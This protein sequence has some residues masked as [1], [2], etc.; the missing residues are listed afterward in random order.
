MMIKLYR[1]SAVE[2]ERVV[3]I[4][5]KLFSENYGV[6]NTSG[7]PI[8]LSPRMWEQ[9]FSIDSVIVAVGTGI[10][11]WEYEDVLG[12]CTFRN[13]AAPNTQHHNTAITSL[14]VKRQYR[15]NRVATYMIDDIVNSISPGSLLSVATRNPVVLDL[16]AL[17]PD[18][19]LIQPPLEDGSGIIINAK[20]SY[21]YNCY[22][23]ETFTQ[24]MSDFPVRQEIDGPMMEEKLDFWKNTLGELEYPGN[25]WIII[26]KKGN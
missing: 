9:K 19:E 23:N 10:L 7:E 5:S 26:C 14:C 8:M 18:M 6:Y 21:I 20:F 1:I 15:R 12:Y 2:N 3:K 4:L 13:Y 16:I 11:N 22:F 17:R 25:E 24:I